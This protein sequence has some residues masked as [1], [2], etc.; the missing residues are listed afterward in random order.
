MADIWGR[1]SPLPDTSG[2]ESRIGPVAR[3]ALELGHAPT[4]QQLGAT[5]QITPW[6]LNKF[7]TSVDWDTYAANFALAASTTTTATG[8]SYTV[9]SNMRAVIKQ[10]TVTVQSL[11]NTSTVTWT[12]L[13]N[14]SPI[15]GYNAVLIPPGTAGLIVMPYNGIDLQLSQG[16]ILTARMTESGGT[17]YTASIAA[18]GWATP[19]ADIQRLQSGLS[20]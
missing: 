12:L 20:V 17:A 13:R 7:T 3:R 19:T 2:L 4:P 8:F 14:G 11:V 6:Y 18:S 15:Q 5:V 1:P 9:P 16:D 10:V